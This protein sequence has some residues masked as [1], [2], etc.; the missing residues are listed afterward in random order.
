MWEKSVTVISKLRS[1]ERDPNPRPL[2]Y[3]ITSHD[4]HIITQ[5]ND[6]FWDKYKLYLQSN[7]RAGT[8]RCQFSY[9]KQY[10]YVITN[11]DASDLLSLT[12][13]KRLL[14]MK[15][16]ANLSKYIGCYDAWLSLKK[17]HQLKWTTD[18]TMHVF[19]HMLDPEQSFD[20]MIK[21]LKTCISTL[22]KADG[23]I[24]IF[25]TLTGLR[26]TEA[27]DSISLIHND[28]D[29]YLNPKM[30][31]LDHFKY[32]RLF[33]RRTKKA[34]TSIVNDEILD[35]AKSSTCRTYNSLRMVLRKHH[36]KANVNHCR[37]IFA[38][39]LH[40]NGIPYEMIDLLQGR[41]PQTVFARHYYKPNLDPAHLRNVI[42]LLYERISSN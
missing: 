38:T 15:S 3:Q 41:S 7:Y 30:M 27:C 32:P 22:P 42:K 36:L 19:D 18:N 4:N 16:I 34:Y 37:K 28:L 35:I 33:L 40:H 11:N 1:F 17:Q 9:A 24:L 2:P 6:A 25:C 10:A 21:W 13:P 29:N 26:P 20:A 8:V 39:H 14:V 12:V 31:V 5:F 23:N